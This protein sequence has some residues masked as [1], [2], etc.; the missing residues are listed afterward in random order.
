MVLTFPPQ[1]R[2]LNILLHSMRL[3]SSKTA[4]PFT[5]NR[6]MNKHIIFGTRWDSLRANKLEKS[7]LINFISK[8]SIT[9]GTNLP[10][11][12]MLPCNLDFWTRFHGLFSIIFKYFISVGVCQIYA[13]FMLMCKW[14]KFVRISDICEMNLFE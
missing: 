6:K 14:L 4:V 2:H 1:R 13:S 12:C 9:N 8:H 7:V 3:Q 5:K 11:N 10:L